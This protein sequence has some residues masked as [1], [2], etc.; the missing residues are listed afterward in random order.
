MRTRLVQYKLNLPDLIPTISTIFSN[1]KQPSFF[2]SLIL[3]YFR[4]QY[5]RYLLCLWQK[6]RKQRPQGLPPSTSL[7]CEGST[8]SRIC[9]GPEGGE[10]RVTPLSQGKTGC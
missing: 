9:G 10:R 1:P 4:D 5:G 6:I 8:S 3:I 7:P 2:D